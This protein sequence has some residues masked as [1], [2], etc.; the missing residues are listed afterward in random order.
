MAGMIGALQKKKRM[1]KSLRLCV[2]LYIISRIVNVILSYS[3]PKFFEVLVEELARLILMLTLAKLFHLVEPDSI[4]LVLTSEGRLAVTQPTTT[5][6]ES[7][8]SQL[9][10]VL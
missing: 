4:T 5:I 6:V 3:V 1:L 9:E 2:M 10:M 7:A 8:K